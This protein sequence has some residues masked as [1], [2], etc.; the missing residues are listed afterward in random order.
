MPSLSPHCYFLYRR[1]LAEPYRANT[2]YKITVKAVDRFGNAIKR[3]GKHDVRARL[4]SSGSGPLP[5]QQETVFE[6]EDKGDGS[7]ELTIAM[8]GPGDIKLVV[9]F[10]LP[11]VQ[12]ATTHTYSHSARSP[13]DTPAQST[14][15]SA[16]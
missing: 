13:C 14:V 9:G 7:Y 11:G 12:T 1:L 8:K 5:A 6:A 10:F 16:H 15:P 2:P 3:G 4:A